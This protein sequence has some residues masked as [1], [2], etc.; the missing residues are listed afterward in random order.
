MAPV[1][2]IDA[3]GQGRISRFIREHRLPSAYVQLIDEH[4]LPLINRVVKRMNESDGWLLGINGAQGTGKTTVADFIKLAIEAETSMNVAVLSIDDFYLTKSER[5][6]LSREIHPLLETRGVP[7]THDLPMLKGCLTALRKLGTGERASLPRFDKARDDRAEPSLWPVV[8]GPVSLII[9]EGW[10]VGSTAE[11][12]SVLQAPLNELERKEDPDGRWRNFVNEQLAGGYAEIFADIDS[13]LFL[14]APS[15]KAI[16]RWRLEQEQKLAASAEAGT[17][18]M[19][20]AQIANFIQ[21][22]ER[23]TRHNLD[24]LPRSA[25]AVFELNEDHGC[26]RSYYN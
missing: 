2:T 23:I 18:L 16:H 8:T 14:K 7:G 11:A 12:S 1:I 24:T 5:R 13:L 10:C 20:E 21:H 15:F 17:G 19:S 4:L 26:T 3:I 25:D 22:Y 9:L 6:A